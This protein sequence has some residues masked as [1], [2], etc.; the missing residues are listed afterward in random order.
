[1]LQP[2]S[3]IPIL[4]ER[5]AWDSD[6]FG[7]AIA[8][9]TRTRASVTELAAAVHWAAAEKI[10]CLYFLADADDPESIRAAEAN[11]CA[12]VD[13]R[14]TLER[15]VTPGVPPGADDAG[16]RRA[17]TEDIPRLMTMARVSHR[18]TRFHV[19]RRFEPQQSDELYAVW[20]ERS[21]RGELADVVLVA[22]AGGALGGYVTIS[23]QGEAAAIGLLAV[24]AACRR[25]GHGARLLDAALEWT[26]E[27]RLTPVSVVTQ[28]S[29][30][31]AI[32]FYERGGFTVRSVQFWYHRWIQ[33]PSAGVPWI[34]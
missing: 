3:E 20:I 34:D 6:F 13:V 1:M 32:R 17:R 15:P 2:V 8:A 14:V 24:D 4:C 11:E 21:V 7:M 31:A 28:G 23:R 22:E 25:E 19:D 5:R 18:N 33:Q 27:Q 26:R 12:L 9:F 16:I 30:A 29:N 10:E